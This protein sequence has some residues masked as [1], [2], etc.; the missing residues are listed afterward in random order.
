MRLIIHSLS[1]SKTTV[2]LL[3]VI[4]AAL[5]LGTVIE[6]TRG[7]EAS[8]VVVYGSWWFILPL[9]LLA[10]NLFL[11]LVKSFPLAKGRLAFVLV[12]ASLLVIMAGAAVTRIWKVEGTLM[13]WEGESG[14][15]IVV[16]QG[17]KR[18][19]PFTVTLEKFVVDTLPGTNWPSSYTSFVQIDDKES[20]H[21]LKS[22]IWMN[23][24]LKYRGFALFQSSYPREGQGTVLAITKDPGQGIVFAGYFALVVGMV[25]ALANSYR[26]SCAS[27]YKRISAPMLLFLPFILMGLSLSAQAPAM[28][29]SAKL[30]RLPVQRDGRVMPFDTCARDMVLDI[31]GT[32]KW[33][34][35]GQVS[36]V[37]RW[38]DA[39]ESA[40]NADVIYIGSTDLAVAMGLPA[41]TKHASF[42]QIV[43]NKGFAQLLELREHMD[44][45]VPTY[46][47]IEPAVELQ[48][49]LGAMK[50][51]LFGSD[52]RPLPMQGAAW[53]PLENATSES[54][55]HLLDG[56]R[57]N[58]WPSEA[59]INCEIF[60]NE[61][62]PVR[63]SWVFALIAI[64]LSIVAYVQKRRWMDV[65]ALLALMC[66]FG[67]MTLC[68][69]LRWLAG[70]RIPAANMY[71][72]MLFL[73]WGLGLSAVVSCC[74][75][76]ARALVLNVAGMAALSML[77]TDLLPM[78]QFI[79]PVVPVL[80]GTP[81]LAIH[82]PIIMV[83]YALLAMGMATAHL[84][85]GAYIFCPRRLDVDGIADRFY[86]M[87]HW[88]NFIGSIALLLG[89]LTGSIWAASSWGSYWKW[90][91]KEVWSLVAFLAYMGIF[92]A[93]AAGLIE[94]FGVAILSILA[95][96][97][98]LMTYLGLNFVVNTGMHTYGMG[99]ALVAVWLL[100]A[101]LL[102][103]I[104]VGL[105]SMVYFRRARSR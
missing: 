97:T 91:P 29:T 31:T 56:P 8:G 9:A 32:G 74:F 104:F 100:I 10:I 92:H 18:E 60:Y 15:A 42:L 73:S 67:M 7:P 52:I 70:E 16:Q 45:D 77:L 58:G 51:I 84:Q 78:D 20:G 50:G 88:Y 102:E 34:G 35:E 90:D 5:V 75:S 26:A 21:T 17:L 53:R 63:I 37:V 33:K 46:R 99:N 54:L 57:L 23:H 94:K 4:M 39:P 22:K 2:V 36:T 79:R 87:L 66:S 12:H 43:Q 69:A 80:S 68:I 65:A 48:Q 28:E 59:K 82:V 13:L 47:A 6:T 95:F 25:W 24:P 105:G 72:S 71:E 3:V 14:S 62:R 44:Y 64:A 103:L 11:A 1:S 76:R 55:A 93:R 101:F 41:S 49:R 61:L 85:V 98:I 38:L 27:A 86:G 19:L 81:W 83:G 96:Q 89:I 40:A 30:A